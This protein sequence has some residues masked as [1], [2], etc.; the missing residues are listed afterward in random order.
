M[1]DKTG[2]F[3]EGHIVKEEWKKNIGKNPNSHKGRKQTDIT[4]EKIRQSMLKQY[5]EGKRDNMKRPRGKDSPNW[6]GG[7]RIEN[8]YVYL[9]KYGMKNGKGIAEHRL[10]M[11]NL[12]GRQVEMVKMKE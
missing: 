9:Y 3:V 5:K 11:A 12:I 7:R 6:K 8:G 1:R 2:R 4:R 10:V